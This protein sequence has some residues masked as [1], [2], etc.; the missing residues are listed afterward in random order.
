MGFTDVVLGLLMIGV[1]SPNVE[2]WQQHLDTVDGS[3]RRGSN[4]TECLGSC[5]CDGGQAD[6][7]FKGMVTFP[8]FPIHDSPNLIITTL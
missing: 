7:S 1:V 4:L 6:C 5:L 2:T 8:T 3:W